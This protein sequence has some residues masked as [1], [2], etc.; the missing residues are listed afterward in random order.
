MP[1]RKQ[2]I[3]PQPSCDTSA[4]TSGTSDLLTL[5]QGREFLDLM[6]RGLTAA[7]AAAQETPAQQEFV[8]HISWRG[9]ELVANLLTRHQY[10]ASAAV[11]IGRHVQALQLADTYLYPQLEL[12]EHPAT[13]APAELRQQLLRHATQLAADAA[14]LSKENRE[15]REA[16]AQAV[17]AILRGVLEADPEGFQLDAPAAAEIRSMTSA[18]DRAYPARL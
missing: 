5:A 7:A 16:A 8:R 6:V 18:F 12:L 13:A 15:H 3:P 9:A 17:V 10:D 4:T 11:V 1:A 14:I 2:P